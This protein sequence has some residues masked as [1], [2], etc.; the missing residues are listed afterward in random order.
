MTKGVSSSST[1]VGLATC[2]VK[3]GRVGGLEKAKERG[4]LGLHPWES[5]AR[6]SPDSP[7]GP[8]PT[9]AWRGPTHITAKRDLLTGRVPVGCGFNL[10]GRQEEQE[11]EEARGRGPG[12]S[13]P[14][15]RA[16]Q[17]GGHVGVSQGR[18][19]W[20]AQAVTP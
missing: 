6:D 3:G 10:G 14:S 18:Q 9:W 2:K 1:R 20:R 16:S 5:E 7:P 8:P 4:K 15:A 17:C 19:G 12:L 11:Q 13:R